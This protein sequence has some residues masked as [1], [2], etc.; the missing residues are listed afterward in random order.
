MYHLIVVTTVGTLHCWNEAGEQLLALPAEE[1][2]K[3][4]QGFKVLDTILN[5]VQSSRWRLIVADTAN[6]QGYVTLPTAPTS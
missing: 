3:L 5:Q 4:N 6:R 2:M 1:L